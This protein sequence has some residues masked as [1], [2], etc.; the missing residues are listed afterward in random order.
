M[1]IKHLAKQMMTM[2][3]GPMQYSRIARGF[4]KGQ[5]AA[6][7]G[8]HRNPFPEGS[9]LYWCW[10]SGHSSFTEAFERGQKDARAGEHH[11]PFPEWLGSHSVWRQGHDSVLR[12]DIR[13]NT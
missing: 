3:H 6:R 13:R 5:S 10:R 7:A 2:N 12:D 4:E 1:S 11:N 9:V 8:K